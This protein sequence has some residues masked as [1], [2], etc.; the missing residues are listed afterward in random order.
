MW[1]SSI[2]SHR[3]KLYSAIIKVVDLDYGHN[4]AISIVKIHLSIYGV[5]VSLAVAIVHHKP[6]L[7]PCRNLSANILTLNIAQNK[8]D[9]S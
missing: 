1:C 9:P 7:L 3:V 5:Q 8:I 2:G 4:I 6:I